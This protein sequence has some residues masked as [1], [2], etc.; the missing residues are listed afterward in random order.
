MAENNVGPASRR[1]GLGPVPGAI[2]PSSR[3]GYPPRP[4]W[5]ETPP[6][7]P[8]PV[9][10]GG[11]SAAPWLTACARLPEIAASHVQDHDPHA[12]S[13]GVRRRGRR[14]RRQLPGLDQGLRRRRGR[15]PRA[16]AAHRALGRRAGARRVRHQRPARARRPRRPAGAAAR[17]DPRPRGRRGRAAPPARAGH[18]HE[19]GA[20]G[21]HPPGAARHR[22]GDPA[23]L[24]AQ[25][26]DHARDAV[27]RHR[28]RA[29]PPTSSATRWRAAAPSSPPTST[30]PSSSR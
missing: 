26:R 7:E 9:H 6:L 27:H 24:R 16:G 4:R 14:L 3:Q 25:G 18:R 30:T 11:G 1:T 13:D 29:S 28:A 12:R 21:A 17:V 10:T 22:A 2:M 8:E 19:R 23:A 15:R 20:E 5:I